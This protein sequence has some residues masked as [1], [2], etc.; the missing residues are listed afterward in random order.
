MPIPIA[1]ALGL[2]AAQAGAQMY[3]QKQAAG[4]ANREGA[5]AANMGKGN[6]SYEPTAGK[7]ALS[8][9]DALKQGGGK[10]DFSFGDNVS[11]TPSAVNSGAGAAPEAGLRLKTALEQDAAP[12]PSAVEGLDDGP[13]KFA[14]M[15]N[16]AM[17][18]GP[19]MQG[20][21]SWLNADTVNAAAGVAGALAG[22]GGGPP[23]AGIPS[24]GNTNFTPTAIR[25]QE[26]L[27]GGGG[28]QRWG[29]F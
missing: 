10:R 19:K 25:L 16:P 26:A 14:Q 5:N 21:N 28:G 15:N 27:A 22:S 29:R 7:N 11:L 9:G 13:N 1:L 2:A 18:A 12:G 20:G 24:L 4:K 6:F 23:G 17:Q 3:A 8:L